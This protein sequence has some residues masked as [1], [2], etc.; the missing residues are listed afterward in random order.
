[1]SNPIPFADL[2]KNQLQDL[3]NLENKLILVIPA[4]KYCN[5]LCDKKVSYERQGIFHSRLVVPKN[6]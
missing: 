5:R 2:S 1:M 4:M 6:N 3:K